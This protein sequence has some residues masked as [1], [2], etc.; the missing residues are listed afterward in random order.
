MYNIL[1]FAGTTEGRE[2]AEY[3]SR[4]EI[5]THVCVATEYGG[6]LLGED[7][8]RT[9][10][11]GRLTADA[12]CALMEELA[13]GTAG[14]LLVVD[15]THPYA[16]EVS[17]NILAACK[18][19][20]A[21]YIRLLRESGEAAGGDLTVVDSVQEAVEFL[22]GTEGNILVT[23]GSKELAKFTELPDFAE[24]VFARVLSTPEVAAACAELGFTGK[25]LICMQG[26]FCEDLNAAMLRQFDAKWMV[27]KESG[28]AGGFEEK[29]R[30]AQKA[31]AHVVLIGRPPEE[32]G[33][34]PFKV[35]AYLMKKLQTKPKR[36]ISIVGIGMGAKDGMT[37]EAKKVCLEAE[38]LVGAK[39]MME[40][41]GDLSKAQFVSYQP[42]EIREYVE[43]HPEFEK[44]A[45]LQSGD[46]GFYSGAKNLYEIFA[47]EEPTVYP[48]ISS[49]VYL[50]AKLHIPWEDVK[51]ISLH[52][53]YANAIAAV[54][55]HKKVFALVGKGESLR[56]LMEKLTY[57]G[58]ADVQVTV[59]EDLSYLGEKIFT[60]TAGELAQE[61]FR[62]LCVVLIENEKAHPVVTHGIADEEFL[63]DAVP[64]T[65]CEVRSI[66]LSKLRLY[67]DSIVYDVGAGTGSVSIEA[68]LQAADGQVYAIEKKPEAAALILANQQKFAVDNLTVITGSAPEALKNLPAPTHVFIGGSSGNMREIL[69]AVLNKNPSVRIVVNCIALETV[70]EALECLKTLPVTDTEIVTVSA[71]RAKEVGRYHMMMGQNPVYIIS[72]SGEAD[73]AGETL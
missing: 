36:Q 9:V 53:R 21:T 37:A 31:G 26:P 27:T 40:S 47:Q 14:G 56:Q 3:L 58:M 51:L 62:G 59:G 29:I 48:G 66:S 11:A 73:A 42:Q 33:L 49:V 12:M 35:R 28:K 17:A 8:Y 30:A 4:Q 20:G 46:V 7:A 41:F 43:A 44:I 68:A 69:E 71:A 61:T 63:R 25:H 64:M 50:C 60:A 23:T 1:I 57:Y 65:K 18:V 34:T 45:L 38:L 39:R 70:A 5:Q 16:A 67:A 72:C 10:H 52:G 54:K 15:A 32:E 6:Q 55:R 24:R 13:E 22:K 19:S 2:L